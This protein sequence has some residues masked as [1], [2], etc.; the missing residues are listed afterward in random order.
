MPRD[1]SGVYT[2]AAGNPVVT[3]TVISSSWANPTMN[4]IAEALTDSLSRTGNGGMLV[5]FK[6][7]DGNKASPAYSF[8]NSPTSGMYWDVATS[9]LRFSVNA[10]DVMSMTL[11]TITFLTENV[12]FTGTNIQ[13]VVSQDSD[14]GAADLPVGTVLERPA[15]P[16][17]GMLRF[18]SD[19]IYVEW[20]DGTE[21]FGSVSKD[22]NTG[23]ADIPTGLLAER[24]AIPT[25]G[26]MRFNTDEINF[27]GYNGTAW[28]AIGAGAT[29][30]A[31][32]PVFFENDINVTVD[33]T[34]TTDKNAMSAGPIIIDNGITVTVPDGSV[35]TIV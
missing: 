4:D 21:W 3:G 2:L 26:M 32:N 7:D 5:P 25:T 24:P 19:A 18:N 27:E 33:Y 28:S 29:G 30:G 1:S 35:W 31:G 6:A 23:A 9:E 10:T 11:D 22:S 20:Y 17:A 14:T 13:G 16:L 15:T 12:N 34:I 8:T